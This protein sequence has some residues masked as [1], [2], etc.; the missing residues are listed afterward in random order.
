MRAGGHFSDFKPVEKRVL[1]NCARTEIAKAPPLISAIQWWVGLKVL[2][3]YV[4]CVET[5]N[6]VC[7]ALLKKV[8]IV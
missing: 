8:T 7:P 3:R 4:Y 2:Y 5:A 6:S 1:E